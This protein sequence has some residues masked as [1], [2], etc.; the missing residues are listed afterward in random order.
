MVH[1]CLDAFV[2]LATVACI[3]Y[4][5]V[6]DL[7]KFEHAGAIIYLCIDLRIFNK[8]IKYYKNYFHVRTVWILRYRHAGMCDAVE[9]NSSWG[10]WSLRIFLFDK[11]QGIQ[12]K[13]RCTLDDAP[14]IWVWGQLQYFLNYTLPFNST[15]REQTVGHLSRM[16]FTGLIVAE[17]IN[18]LFSK[19]KSNKY[20]PNASVLLF[21]SP[22][23]VTYSSYLPQL[24]CHTF[25]SLN[26]SSPVN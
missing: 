20:G 22:G 25:W 5:W 26:D 11:P 12:V 17:L 18:Y 19:Q 4:R 15:P 3:G 14:L 8:C 24:A 2:V 21:L 13:D 23:W 7:L 1:I 10:F 6:I 9:C 16:N